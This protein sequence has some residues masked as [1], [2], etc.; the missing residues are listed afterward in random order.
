MGRGAVARAVAEGHGLGRAVGGDFE[1]RAIERQL[2]VV[3]AHGHA[4]AAAQIE[5]HARVELFLAA[6]GVVGENEG[7]RCRPVRFARA[8]LDLD[9]PVVGRAVVQRRTC[10]AKDPRRGRA[11]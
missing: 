8:V 6:Q 4:P 1:E 7:G 3:D 9:P 5:R 11:G 2:A 10:D